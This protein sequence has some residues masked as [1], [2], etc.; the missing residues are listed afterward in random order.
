MP[1]IIL[2]AK[3]KNP[4]KWMYPPFPKSIPLT[5]LYATQMTRYISYFTENKQTSKTEDLSASLNYS[6]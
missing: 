2:K 1:Q 3:F 6:A 4:Y 5:E